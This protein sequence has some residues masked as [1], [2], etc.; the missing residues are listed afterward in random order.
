MPASGGRAFRLVLAALLLLGNVVLP[1][2]HLG[3]DHD[4]AA[5]ETGH[6]LHLPDPHEHATA[7][8][9]VCDLIRLGGSQVCDE[10]GA[11][12]LVVPLNGVVRPVTLADD[13][14]SSLGPACS[15][16]PPAKV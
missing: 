9:R 7:D 8:C 10:P 13:G 11:V 12:A 16:A 14:R 5:A 6:S 15:R 3:V 1:S 2:V 4:H